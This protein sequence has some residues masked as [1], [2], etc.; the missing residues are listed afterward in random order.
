MCGLDTKSKP[1]T[2]LEHF[3]SSSNHTGNGMQFIPMEKKSFSTETLFV[4]PGKL[5]YNFK[6]AKQVIPM[7][8]ASAKKHIIVYHM[9]IFYLHCGLVSGISCITELLR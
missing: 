4:R 7:V 1:T 6:K 3:L 8:S 5:F 9:V 2:A